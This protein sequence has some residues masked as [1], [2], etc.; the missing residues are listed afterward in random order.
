MRV[1]D[2]LQQT[3]S[4]SLRLAYHLT[5]LNLVTVVVSVVTT[6]PQVEEYLHGGGNLCR[7][8]PPGHPH[9]M[10]MAP[11]SMSGM[12]TMMMPQISGTCPEWYEHRVAKS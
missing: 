9:P 3:K 12:P 11:A 4:M 2:G 10:E 6:V 7:Q 5:H 8:W 1:H